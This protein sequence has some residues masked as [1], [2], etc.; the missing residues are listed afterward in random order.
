VHE[1]CAF[2]AKGSLGSVAK[3]VYA[4]S[5][6]AK[7][8]RP[9]T[10]EASNSIVK[11]TKASEDWK[12]EAGFRVSNLNKENQQGSRACKRRQEGGL[13]GWVR[14]KGKFEEENFPRTWHE[15]LQNFN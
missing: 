1:I 5:N 12:M 13:V 11:K 2:G 14:F 7:A 3:E 10:Q 4:E 8:P 6:S 9:S 15:G